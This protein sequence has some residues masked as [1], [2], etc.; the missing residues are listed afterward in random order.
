MGTDTDPTGNTFVP[1]CVSTVRHKYG[2]RTGTTL[3][4]IHHIYI[5]I[6]IYV[7]V[8]HTKTRAT[9]LQYLEYLVG[10]CT[11]HKL[12][13]LS[14]TSQETYNYPSHTTIYN[15]TANIY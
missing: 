1:L 9:A 11:G 14:L 7:T 8:Y 15:N 2:H 4:T 10:L 13:S 3:D 12:R 5:Y 6:Y